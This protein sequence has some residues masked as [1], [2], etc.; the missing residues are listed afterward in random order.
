[1]DFNVRKDYIS[2]CE[3]AFQGNAEHAVDC[4]ITLPEYLPDIVRDAVQVP[5]RS[6]TAF[7]KYAACRIYDF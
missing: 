3:T 4:D 2:V 7:S 6:A 5:G 1:M